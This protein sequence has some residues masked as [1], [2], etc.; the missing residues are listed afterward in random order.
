[1]PLVLGRAR[2]SWR[3]ATGGADHTSVE[4]PLGGAD[5][6]LTDAAPVTQHRGSGL[7]STTRSIPR[8]LSSRMLRG[9]CYIKN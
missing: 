1:M 7:K 2:R 8:G 4:Q 9:G 6:V 3:G 5:W